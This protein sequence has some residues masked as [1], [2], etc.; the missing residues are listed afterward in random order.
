M[1]PVVP[2]LLLCLGLGAAAAAQGNAIDV[3]HAWARATP[4][5]ARTGAVYLTIVNNGSAED[6]LNGAAAASVAAKAQL[7]SMTME[8][9]VMRMRPLAGVAVKGGDRVE[10]DPK[11]G[12]HIMLLGL[13]APLKAG[14]TFPMTLDFDKAGAV[15]VTVAVEKAGAMGMSGGKM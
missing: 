1:K 14:E 2:A 9:G 12:M 4:A 13:K 7:H 3:E 5:G 10:L 15:A 8:N 11:N 6:K